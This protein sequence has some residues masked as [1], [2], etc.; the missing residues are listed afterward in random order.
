M[1]GFSRRIGRTR[2][3]NELCDSELAAGGD[4]PRGVQIVRQGVE[5][6]KGRGR[7]DDQCALKSKER[8]K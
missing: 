8:E 5:I 7:A 6:R 1:E 4:R 2:V 3:R